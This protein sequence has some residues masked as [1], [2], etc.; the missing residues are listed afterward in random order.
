MVS[1]EKQRLAFFAAVME[2]VTLNEES[3]LKVTET[4]A[5]GP[6]FELSN[7]PTYVPLTAENMVAVNC[8]ESPFMHEPVERNVPENWFGSTAGAAGER[9]GGSIVEGYGKGGLVEAEDVVAG[10]IRACNSA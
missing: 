4:L 5:A 1:V 10:D 3:V 8:P 9:D 2:P 6:P 7:E